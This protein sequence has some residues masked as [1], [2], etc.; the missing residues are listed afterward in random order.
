MK[1]AVF[2]GSFD[3]VTS[4]HIDILKQAAPLFDKIY[5]AV[6]VNTEKK[7]MFSPA[8]RIEMLKLATAGITNV[9]VGSFS[10]F[11]TDY[12]HAVSAEYI[13]RGIRNS[14]DLEYEKTLSE[15]YG[16]VAPDVKKLYFLPEAVNQN[17]NSTVAR[18]LIIHGKSLNGLLPEAVIKYIKEK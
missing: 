16:M 6:L 8:E 11:T 18:E 15:A 1:I 5:A 2:P 14:N 10:G 4:G 3:P 17:V 9:E 12:C 7:T 13:I